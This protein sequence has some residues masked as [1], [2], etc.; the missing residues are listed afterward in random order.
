MLPRLLLLLLLL[1]LAYWAVAYLSRRFGLSRGRRRLLWLFAVFVLTVAA[2]VLLGRLPV[3][4]ILAPIGVAFA[5]LLR[6]LPALFRW[7]PLWGMLRR[8]LGSRQGGY[9]DGGASSASGGAGGGGSAGD[10][11]SPAADSPAV[12]T[13]SQ[14]L[15]ILGLPPEADREAVIKAHR[16]LM[17]RLHPDRGGSDYLAK[18]IN[19][20]KDFLLK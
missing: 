7:L 18:R 15:Q 17:G 4:A 10:P 3:H 2:L 8:W 9:Y 13:R 16:S 5:F 19:Q 1:L 14:A 20:A 6:L 12:M 11:N